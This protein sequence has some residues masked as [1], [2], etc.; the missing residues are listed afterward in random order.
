M[1]CQYKVTTDSYHAHFNKSHCMTCP[2]RKRCGVIFQKKTSLIRISRKTILRAHSLQKIS[3]ARYKQIARQ[4]NAVEGMPSVLRRRY[5]VDHMPVRGYVRTK[6]W[7]YLKIGA[8]NVMRVLAAA[9]LSV[10]CAFFRGVKQ[11]IAIDRFMF[12]PYQSSQLIF[13]A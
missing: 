7:Y 4:R 2:H 8:I 12:A 9:S 5:Q 3:E 1:R 13:C 11:P 10:V 6:C